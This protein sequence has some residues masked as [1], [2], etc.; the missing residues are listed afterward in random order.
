MRSLR[1]SWI[2]VVTR[3][4]VHPVY[5]WG[6][7]ALV[8]SVPLRLALSNTAAWKAFASAIVALVS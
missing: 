2:V 4:R 6:G 3:R 8:L 7:S 1:T 5:L